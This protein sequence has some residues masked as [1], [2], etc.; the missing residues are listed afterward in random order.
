MSDTSNGILQRAYTHIEN[1]EPEKAQEI[2]APLLQDDANN[3]HLW[4]V[5]THAVSDASIGQAALAN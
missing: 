2:L 5:Y 4:W 1:D 3:A